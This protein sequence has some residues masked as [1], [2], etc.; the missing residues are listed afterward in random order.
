LV[1]QIE[2][3]GA[4][5]VKVGERPHWR[6]GSVSSLMTLPRRWLRFS[7]ASLITL[8]HRWA[9]GRIGLRCRP[10][11][12]LEIIRELT[13]PARQGRDDRATLIT[14]PHRWPRCRIDLRCRPRRRLEIIRELT[15]PARQ[16]RDDVAC[17]RSV[18]RAG[19]FEDFG[20]GPLR[21]IEPIRPQPIRFL[22]SVFSCRQRYRLQYYSS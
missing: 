1:G 20:T 4:G 3:G 6:A 5:V 19:E 7:R 10:R 18:D 2:P 11:R 15:L 8:P 13:L 22:F 14:L 9:R 12:R 17:P 21:R 16:G